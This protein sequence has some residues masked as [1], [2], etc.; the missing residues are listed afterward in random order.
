MKPKLSLL[1]LVTMVLVAQ[2]RASK[3]EFASIRM[4]V[5]TFLG[6]P[7]AGATIA[8]I[9][10]GTQKELSG[11]FSPRGDQYVAS[12]V[13]FGEY[14]LRVSIGGT[15]R[16]EQFINVQQPHLSFRVFMRL[17]RFTDEAP[18]VVHGTIKSPAGTGGL[19]VKM[20]PLLSTESI[21]ETEVDRDGG[22]RLVGLDNGEYL[23]V[24]MRGTKAEFMKQ[25][26]LYGLLDVQ[27]NV[28]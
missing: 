3:T 24:V 12:K 5:L 22:F 6:E 26:S 8:L 4:R 9:E 15:R 19:W 28:P 10:R 16:H 20:L 2:C 7:I 18:S 25:V 21:G 17:A 11:A 14:L 13:P 27:L 23:L 1:V